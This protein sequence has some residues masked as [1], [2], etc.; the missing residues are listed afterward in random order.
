MRVTTQPIL[1][2]PRLRLRPYEVSDL[3]DMAAMF[4][5]ADVTAYTFLGRRDR[6]QTAAVLDGYMAFLE[7]RGYGMLA[8]TDGQ[9][10]AYLGEVGTFVSPMGDL[11]LRYALAKAG[12]GRGYAGEASA[13]VL[14]DHFDRLGLE[15]LVAGVKAENKASVRVMEKLGFVYE[16]TI[17]ESGHTFGVFGMTR[18]AW[19][20]RPR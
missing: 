7:E 1:A 15:R 16:R 5:D 9:T 19:R 18:A 20:A 12:W 8:I 2:T 17:T 3:D 10:G 11:A 4:G 13:A 14:D 6:A